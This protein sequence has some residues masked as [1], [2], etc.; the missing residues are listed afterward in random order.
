MNRP[1]FVIVGRRLPDG[2]VALTASTTVRSGGDPSPQSRVSGTSRLDPGAPLYEPDGWRIALEIERFTNVN[3]A[4]YAE[5][6]TILLALWRAEADT[7]DS[8]VAEL[9]TQRTEAERRG[10]APPL[11]RDALGEGDLPGPRG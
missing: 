6:L 7:A 10:G 1:D 4:D 9:F 5:A 8:P 3:G 2:T 11:V